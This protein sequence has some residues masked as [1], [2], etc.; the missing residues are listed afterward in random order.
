MMMNNHSEL[1]ELTEEI[2]CFTSEDDPTALA[3]VQLAQQLVQTAVVLAQEAADSLGD[4][5]AQAYL[6]DQ[7]KVLADSGHGFLS[8]DFNFDRWIEQIESAEDEADE[9]DEA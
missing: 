9:D 8:R 3:K 6:V 1:S 4:R 7:L 5:H 2:E